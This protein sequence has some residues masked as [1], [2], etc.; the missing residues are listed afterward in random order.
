MKCIARLLAFIA[1]LL[2]WSSAHAGCIPNNDG[3]TWTPVN[4]TYA[5]TSAFASFGYTSNGLQ[6]HPPSLSGSAIRQDCKDG[7]GGIT[8]AS[9]SIASHTPGDG[10]FSAQTSADIWH[11]HLRVYAQAKGVSKTYPEGQYIYA[12]GSAQGLTMLSEVV[13]FNFPDACDD[14]TLPCFLTDITLE[15]WVHGAYQI[16]QTGGGSFAASAYAF[17]EGY[18]GVCCGDY[19]Q[20][21]VNWTQGTGFASDYVVNQKLGDWNPSYGA[22]F[23]TGKLTLLGQH[24]SA[25]ISMTLGAE[26][27]SF[28]ET[29]SHFSFANTAGFEFGELPPGTTWTSGSGFFLQG[30]PNGVPEPTTLALI[31]LGLAGI[32]AARRKKLAA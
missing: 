12:G 5:W 3:V 14:H 25:Y 32:G 28:D 29:F 21:G 30:E 6:I 13:R 15:W 31:G 17:P 4:P 2:G 20:L 7:S 23:F 8:L 18:E 10:Y 19:L 16:L 1:A 11:G 22:P 26:L 9:S 27:A 24:P